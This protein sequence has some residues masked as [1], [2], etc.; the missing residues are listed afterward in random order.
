MKL[1]EC[2]CGKE[3]KLLSSKFCIGHNS[4]SKE[5]K[6]KYKQ[7][8]MNKYGVESPLQSKEFQE[9]SKQTYLKHFGTEHPMQ[10][11]EIKEKNKQTCLNHFGVEH[12]HQSKKIREKFK[13]TMM[14]RHGVEH[15][16]QSEESHL[17][18]KHTMIKN[19]GVEYSLQS[20]EI[21]ERINQTC[22]KIYGVKNINQLEEIKERKIQTCL[23]NYGVKHPYQSE[24]VREKGKQSCIEHHGVDNYAKTFEFR[25]FAREQMIATVT[26]GLKDG[27]TF[28]PSKGKNEKSFIS[29]L[30]VHSPYFI[31]NNAKIIG[32]F[33]DGYIKE[34]NLVIEFD[35]PWHNNSWS[36][37]HDKQKDE[38][39]QKTGL[40]I[41][42][43][44]EKQWKENKEQVINQFK[45][46][47]SSGDKNE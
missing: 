43:V 9:K 5:F 34:L 31:D 16:L 26:A 47:V 40:I 35:E 41:F 44:S 36:K 29:D 46:L 28:S 21:Q 39:Y 6:E 23:E 45:E 22:F 7:T 27:Q 32:Y 12:S 15:A 30:Q 33:P 42:R 10:V 18:F 4:R 11:K 1:C 17:K 19:H 38:D 25:Q 13:Q 3:V 37:K 20:K 2:G 14:R 24:I 8:C